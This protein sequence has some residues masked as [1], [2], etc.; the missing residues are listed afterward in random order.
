MERGNLSPDSGGVCLGTT[1]RE[2]RETM[3]SRRELARI[4]IESI[5]EGDID[6][7]WFVIG[8]LE[9]ESE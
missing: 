1:T 5:Q 7:V 9:R 8:E 2:E 6:G 3:K 4:L